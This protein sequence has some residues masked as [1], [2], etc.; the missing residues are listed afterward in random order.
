[1]I[2][3]VCQKATRGAIFVGLRGSDR[4]IWGG[5]IMIWGTMA[6]S[7]V[8]SIK[9]ITDRLNAER[10][11]ALLR[12]YLQPDGRK[13]IGQIFTFQQDGA[14]CHTATSTFAMI[15]RSAVDLMPWPAQSPDQNPIENLWRILKAKLSSFSPKKRQ[16]VRRSGLSGLGTDI[17]RRHKPAC[18]QHA[19]KSCCR[20]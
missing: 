14:P 11:Q 15:H 3:T 12:E 2:M 5:K 20:C 4:Q 17:G 18:W 10:Y 6:A 13:L 16:R 19:R 7:G 9:V 1:M 8:G